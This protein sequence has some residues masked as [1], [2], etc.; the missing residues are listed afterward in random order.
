[1]AKA[2]LNSLR[3]RTAFAFVLLIVAAFAALGIYLTNRVEGAFTD[4]IEDDLI[5]QAQMVEGALLQLLEEGVA[6]VAIDQVAKQLSE[7][8]DVEITIVAPDGQVLGDSDALPAA[9]EPQN[10]QPEI[11]EALRNGRGASNRRSTT[12]DEQFTYVASRVTIG[13]AVVAVVRVGRPTSAVDAAVADITRSVLIAVAVTAA[14]AAVLSFAVGSA[15]ME[16]LGRLAR[17]ARSIAE[18]N[19]A[20]RVNPRPSGEAGE[21]ADAFNQMAGSLEQLVAAA[22]HERNRLVAALNSSVDAVA[23]LDPQGNIAFANTAAE[24]LFDH[25]HDELIG[26]PFSWAMPDQDV[27]AAL[28]SSQERNQR[29]VLLIEDRSRR[30]YLHVTTAPIDGGGDWA[31]LVVCHDLTDMKQT[32]QVRRDFVA[33][34]SHE[35]RTP[36]AALKSV[37]ETLDGGA[38]EEPKAAREFLG[39]ANH[40]V[41]RLI[42]LV[43]ELLELSRI[44]SGELPMANQ[45]IELDSV[46]E[47]ATERMQRLAERQG[48]QLDFEA[49]PDLPTVM[50]DAERLERVAVNL[51]SNALKFTPA[52][53]TVEVRATPQNGTVRVSVR[54]TGIGISRKDLPRVFER[55]YKAD[56][57]RGGAGTGLGLAIVKHTVEAH[58]GEVSVESEEGAGSTFSFSIRLSR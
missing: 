16:P 31:A 18:G 38:L 33:N 56:R 30:R 55:F 32:D 17:A 22:A 25:S 15:M 12:R 10:D 29:Q 50:G 3:F 54:D 28:R 26:R 35:L 11:Q 4:T 20:E 9:R 39:R 52:G 14:A 41:D 49:A 58:G 48:V 45:P 44:E 19:L 27:I 1:M 46:L 7:G 51:I 47:R 57:A 21:L 36:L 37:I 23:A 24:E 40:E 2:L 6:P 53:G 8:S 42:Q 34:V 5:V 43:E 13:D